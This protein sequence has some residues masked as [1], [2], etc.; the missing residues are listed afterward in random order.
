MGCHGKGGHDKFAPESRRC[1]PSIAP[2]HRIAWTR[3]WIGLRPAQVPR[4]NHD[5]AANDDNLQSP[6]KT[7]AVDQEYHQQ[8]PQQST[9]IDHQWISSGFK[10]EVPLTSV[11]DH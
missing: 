2:A 1:G 5:Q 10:Y 3:H 6:D 9:D 8:S 11:K 4:D 7:Q